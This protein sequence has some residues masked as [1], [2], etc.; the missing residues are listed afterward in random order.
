[1]PSQAG[2]TS[3]PPTTAMASPSKAATSGAPQ[4]GFSQLPTALATQARVKGSW[5]AKTKGNGWQLLE[6][7]RGLEKPR[8]WS[9]HY[10]PRDRVIMWPY[11]PPCYPL[12]SMFMEEGLLIWWCICDAKRKSWEWLF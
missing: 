10:D 12:P 3:I 5:R 1:M 6:L 11:I 7:L 9:T 8:W 4:V 2:E